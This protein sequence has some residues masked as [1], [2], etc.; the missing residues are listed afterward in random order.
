MPH[1]VLEASRDMLDM[2]VIDLWWRFFALGGSIDA[3]QLSDYL[4][5][6]TGA[7]D[8]VHDTIVHALNETFSE[9][10]HDYSPV[11]YRHDTTA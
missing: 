8:D 7:T 5:G 4:A 3:Y 11:P 2:S 1:L 10:G 6:R 9:R